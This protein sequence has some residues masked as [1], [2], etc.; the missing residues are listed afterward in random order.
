MSAN[1]AAELHR[2]ASG[3][4]P[5]PSEPGCRA[6]TYREQPGARLGKQLAPRANRAAARTSVEGAVEVWKLWRVDGGAVRPVPTSPLSPST[7]SDPLP[8]TG[9]AQRLAKRALHC[10]NPPSTRSHARPS[11]YYPTSFLKEDR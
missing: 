5:G 7:C 4:Q 1:R 6:A 3:L 8:G 11:Y 10:A 9:L 2:A